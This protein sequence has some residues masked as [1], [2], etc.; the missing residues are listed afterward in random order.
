MKLSI[1][2]QPNARQESLVLKDGQV[3]IKLRAKAVDGAANK[4]LINFLAKRFSIARSSVIL[5]SG[6]RSRYKVVEVPDGLN[7]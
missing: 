6:E 1:T 4:A 7:F 3:K 5:I 2:V